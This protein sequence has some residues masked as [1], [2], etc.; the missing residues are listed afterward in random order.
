MADRPF[1]VCSWCR[2][3]FH[4]S[5]GP[6]T[7]ISQ[8]P[9]SVASTLTFC[10]N[11]GRRRPHPVSMDVGWIATTRH[12]SMRKVDCGKSAR[13]GRPMNG[14]SQLGPRGR[15][16]SPSPLAPRIVVRKALEQGWL[17]SKSEMEAVAFPPIPPASASKSDAELLELSTRATRLTL[18]DSR[19]ESLSPGRRL[20]DYAASESTSAVTLSTYS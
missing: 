15:V 14:A 5:R 18:A 19:R 10:A 9:A 16:R 6:V 2:F 17:A 4:P 12:P 13:R 20:R 3:S 8:R 11:T 7:R 1:A